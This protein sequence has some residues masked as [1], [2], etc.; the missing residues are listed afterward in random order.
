[1]KLKTRIATTLGVIAVSGGLVTGGY[2]LFS[3][4]NSNGFGNYYINPII[5]N[6]NGLVSAYNGARLRGAELILTPGF[7]HASPIE[8]IFKEFP[9]E[10]KDI[11]F[12]LYDANVFSNTR[13]AYNTWSVTF[14]TDLGSI[15]V[16]IA[17][18]YFLNYY[19]DFFADEDD[20]RLTWATWGGQPYSSV[21]SYMGGIQL[22]IQWA[23]E[24]MSGKTIHNPDSDG[25]KGKDFTYKA[26]E[27]IWGSDGVEWTGGFSESKGMNVMSNILYAKPDIVIPV[28]GP[29][30]WTAQSLI[31]N[32]KGSKTMLIGVDSACED[33]PRNEPYP[34][35]YNGKP[36]GNGKN[37][38]FSSLKR[39]DI[40]GEKALNIVNNG[41]ALPDGADASSYNGFVTPAGETGFGT[42][43][44]GNIENKCVGI[45]EAGVSYFQAGL[46]LTG[47]ADPANDP[48]YSE[49]ANMVYR[50]KSKSYPYGG[51]G[52][53]AKECKLNVD[54]KTKVLNK[55]G[56]IKRD[57]QSCKDLIKIILSQSNAIL[58]DASFSQSC[59]VGL[60]EYYKSMGI[61]IPK[62]VG[63]K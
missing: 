23:N 20:N 54:D 22:G 24:N 21:T 16:G 32:I 39:L 62:P 7:N 36:I 8:E 61:N 12:L 57:D 43:A 52:G 13:A 45:S 42:C 17:I 38:I 49:D 56:I 47:L 4:A 50:G 2:F 11:G 46:T 19:Q 40:A 55:K 10:F 9:S 35:K 33:D 27:Q 41:N 26:V 29:Q 6:P 15:Q 1:M 28:A 60:Y 59:Y 51:A 30:I 53:L 25:G 5:D 58:M 14:R 18:A 44:V 37:I 31:K 63:V 48:K 3:N 34:Y